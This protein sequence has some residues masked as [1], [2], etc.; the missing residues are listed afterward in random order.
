MNSIAVTEGSLSR[1]NT[2]R[3]VHAS[4]AVKKQFYVTHS[5][6]TVAEELAINQTVAHLIDAVVK[7]EDL[8]RKEDFFLEQDGDR[9]LPDQLLSS[10]DGTELTLREDVIFLTLYEKPYCDDVV[11][12]SRM[13]RTEWIAAT[14]SALRSRFPR[15]T[16]PLFGFP[17]DWKPGVLV[18]LGQNY[19]LDS[20]TVTSRMCSF[21]QHQ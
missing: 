19:P 21:Y 20:L 1:N 3:K 12:T 13:S 8:D 14:T 16:G 2:P 9:L 6:E 17:R 18:K 11:D 10:L 7:T 15:A 4:V 5:G